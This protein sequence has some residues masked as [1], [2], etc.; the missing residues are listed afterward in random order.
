M[1]HVNRKTSNLLRLL[2]WRLVDYPFQRTKDRDDCLRKS[3]E[4]KEEMR[5]RSSRKFLNEID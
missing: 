1:Y 2:V 4:E 3:E 5:V